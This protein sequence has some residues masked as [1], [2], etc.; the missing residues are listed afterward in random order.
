MDDNSSQTAISAPLATAI[1]SVGLN[2]T[3]N[4]DGH[5]GND[6]NIHLFRIFAPLNIH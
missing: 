1:P 6:L 2:V 3:L 4:D 5:G